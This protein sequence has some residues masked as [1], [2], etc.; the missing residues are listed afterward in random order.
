MAGGGGAVN[1]HA[2][3]CEGQAQAA[4]GG[5]PRSAAAQRAHAGR[6]A[7]RQPQDAAARGA[8]GLALAQE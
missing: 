8:Q 4:Q 6:C 1:P 5:L 3:G 7:R 2:P